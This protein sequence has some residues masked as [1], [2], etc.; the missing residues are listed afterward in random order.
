M[1]TEIIDSQATKESDCTFLTK[2]VWHQMF[3]GKTFSLE[4]RSRIE[5][6]ENGRRVERCTYRNYIISL[7]Q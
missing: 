6:E 5:M 3:K 1:E 7:K 4:S 2:S